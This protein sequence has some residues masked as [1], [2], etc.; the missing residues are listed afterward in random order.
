MSYESEFDNYWS[1]IGRQL[2]RP[3]EP[4]EEFKLTRTPGL[5]FNDYKKWKKSHK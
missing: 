5:T 4:W 3:I 2:G 1:W